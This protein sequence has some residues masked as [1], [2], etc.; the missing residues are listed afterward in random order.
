MKNYLRIR[1]A[2]WGQTH[3]PFFGI[4][5][6]NKSAPRDGRHLERVGTYNPIPQPLP[7]EHRESLLGGEGV[8]PADKKV[9]HITLNVDRIKYWLASGAQPSSRVEWLLAKV[10]LLY[11]QVLC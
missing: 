3:S 4:V 7:S 6:T 10:T 11:N 9:K 1:L 5:V 2:S 8:K